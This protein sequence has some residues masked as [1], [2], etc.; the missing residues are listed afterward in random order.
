VVVVTTD[1]AVYAETQR[2][3]CAI[4]GNDRTVKWIPAACVG[5]LRAVADP[6]FGRDATVSLAQRVLP[7]LNE[8]RFCCSHGASVSLWL[9]HWQ[10]AMALRLRH[11]AT[12]LRKLRGD[13]AHRAGMGRRPQSQQ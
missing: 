2:R 12:D 3:A 7:L 6:G 4:G 8:F 11:E 5:R 10:T 1:G 9:R 13:A